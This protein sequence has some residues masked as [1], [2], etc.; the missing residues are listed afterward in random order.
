MDRDTLARLASSSTPIHRFTRD[1]LRSIVALLDERAETQRINRDAETVYGLVADVT[2]AAQ[3][4]I[5]RAA[6]LSEYI[7]R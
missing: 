4:L 5:K 2:A 1:E 3:D 6:A 7:D